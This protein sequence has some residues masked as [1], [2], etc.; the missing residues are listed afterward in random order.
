MK[1]LYEKSL[2]NPENSWGNAPGTG[3]HRKQALKARVNYALV[4]IPNIA[5]VEFDTVLAQ[6]LA[7]FPLKCPRTMVRWLLLNVFQHGIELIRTHL[8]SAISALP[9]K[10][11]IPRVK[12]FDPF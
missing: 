8:K 4:S 1:I 5:L 12:R 6:Q 3:S 2:Y 9:E 7:V 10:A 11:A